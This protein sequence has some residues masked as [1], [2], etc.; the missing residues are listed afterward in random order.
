MICNRSQ[1]I[2]QLRKSLRGN[3]IWSL[4]LSAKNVHNYDL[5]LAVFREPYLSFI[6][7]GR[8]RIETRFAKRPCPP[9]EGVAEGDVVILKPSGGKIVG[10]FEVERV[11]FYRLD[12]KSLA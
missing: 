8:K 10:I 6:M 11:W 12:P 2:A 4:K 3:E 5:H 7:D 1:L 9:F